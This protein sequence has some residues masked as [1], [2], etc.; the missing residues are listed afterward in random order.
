M[1]SPALNDFLAQKWL[2]LQRNRK[3]EHREFGTTGVKYDFITRI[4]Q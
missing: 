2:S 1:L 3:T 4:L